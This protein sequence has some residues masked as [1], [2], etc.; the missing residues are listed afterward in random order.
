MAFP[1]DDLG[2][3]YTIEG[4]IASL[5]LI[6]VLLFIIQAN[7]LIIPQTEKISDMKLQQRA[8]DIM[9]CIQISNGSNS[10]NDLKTYVELWDGT[11]ADTSSN[12]GIASGQMK[13]ASG[14]TISLDDL[15]NSISSR[16]S[17]GEQYSVTVSYEDPSKNPSLQ[18]NV[19]III[20][21]QP[22]DSSVVATRLVT[23]YPE[24]RDQLSS[25]WR[26]ND[27]IKN[28]LPVVVDVKIVCWYI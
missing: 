16:L 7:S 5:I 20:K 12:G 14:D 11:K 1:K 21:G 25:F 9:T 4:I 3:L 22:G 8:N 17:E 10:A 13:D 27:K 24:D 2:Q 19:P 28:N 26:N 15:N 18:T 23:L 6:G